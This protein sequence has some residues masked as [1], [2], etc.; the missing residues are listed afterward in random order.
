MD[1][2][3]LEGRTALVTYGTAIR[4]ASVVL[5]ALAL[6]AW[7]KLSGAA[8]A[9]IAIMIGVLAEALSAS[10]FAR[11]VIRSLPT[12]HDDGDG[13][14]AQP[15]FTRQQPDEGRDDRDDHAGLERLVRIADVVNGEADEVAGGAGAAGVSSASAVVDAGGTI[16]HHHAV[17]RMHRPAW[18]QQRPPLF[19]EALRAIKARLDANVALAQQIKLEFVDLADQVVAERMDMQARNADRNRLRLLELCRATGIPVSKAEVETE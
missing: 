6:V 7:G 3:S 1:P 13:D 18:E 8:T 14:P 4:L 15:A 2:F 10:S 17:G 9:A 16:T 11:P 19:A 12:H 5:P